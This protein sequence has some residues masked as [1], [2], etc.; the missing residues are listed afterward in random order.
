M[1]PGRRRLRAPAERAKPPAKRAANAASP[2]CGG[3]AAGRRLDAQTSQNPTKEGKNINPIKGIDLSAHQKAGQVN[4]E[5]LKE[6]GYEFVML[7][8]GYGM[9]DSQKDKAFESHYE[10]ATK[11]GLK[12]GAYHYS[13]AKNVSQAIKEADCFLKWIKGKKLE[14]PVAFDIEDRSQKI[15]SVKQKTDIALAFMQKVEA[16][17]YYTMLYSSA[18][19]LN[20]YLDMQK[21][22]HFDVWLA[23]YTSKE[24]RNK[25]YSGKFGMW[26]KTS[27]L[28]LPQVY[29]S[30]L[31]ENLAYKDYARIIHKNRLNNL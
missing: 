18:N 16:A 28:K 23:C 25:L 8:A 17:G 27:G 1:P 22:R 15:L 20:K 14:Y 5:K 31:D 2:P 26:Q 29:S 19:W 30:R 3:L 9:Y 11:A 4:F 12:V 21:L 6:L 13:Y 10:A 24:R 7:R